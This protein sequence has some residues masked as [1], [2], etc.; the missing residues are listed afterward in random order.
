M[1]AE[2]NAASSAAESSQDKQKLLLESPTGH[3]SLIKHVSRSRHPQ[4]MLTPP[5]SNRAMHLADLITELNG[6]C[7]FMSILCSL[8]YC[9]GPPSSFANAWAALAFMPFG[10]FFDFM[11]GKVARWRGKSSLMGQELD[12]LAD[13]PPADAAPPFPAPQISFG[14]APAT[15]AFAL[16]LRTP[17]DAL[18]LAFFVLCG[19]TRLARFNVTVAAVPKDA[20]GKSKYFEGTP[21]PTT[22]AI[23][24]AMAYCLGQGRV[25][26]RIPGGVWGADVLGGGLAVHPVV[27][28]FAVW[29]G[30][31]TSRSIR[32]PKI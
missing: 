3:F 4:T 23:A 10:L 29:G 19:L 26:E 12:S 20:T 1:P 15:F 17:L 31:M 32:I 28:V 7:G 30:M 16:G 9:L 14:V 25:L 27:G 21:I 18:V 8:R 13:L 11:D 24:A 2:K 6:F 5:S 22:L